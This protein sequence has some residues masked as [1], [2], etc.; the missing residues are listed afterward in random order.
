[1]MTP[2]YVTSAA[3]DLHSYTGGTIVGVVG[4]SIATTAHITSYCTTL[5]GCELSITQRA[6]GSNRPIEPVT[7]VS[8]R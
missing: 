4:T 7:H 3:C 8:R 5:H 2:R 1:M 6:I